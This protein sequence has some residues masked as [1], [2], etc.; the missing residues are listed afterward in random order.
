MT[1]DSKDDPP[2]GEEAPPHPDIVARLLAKRYP[3]RANER[4]FADV[5]PKRTTLT[6]G[7]ADDRRQISIRVTYLRGP[8]DGEPW[9]QVAD[10]A[11]ALFGT[12]IEADR[13]HRALPRGAEVEHAGAFF[14]VDVTHE[15]PQL[16]R[17]ADQ[18]L[19]LSDDEPR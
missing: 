2:P 17:L 14:R 9:M 12:L 10:A 15:I 5:D 16:E 4:V 18:I 6:V 11:D 1:S 7:L 19:G 13:N 8:S 3:V